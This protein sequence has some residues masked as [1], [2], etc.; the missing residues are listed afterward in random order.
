[1]SDTQVA[2]VF[3]ARLLLEADTR[4]TPAQLLAAAKGKA[5]DPTVFDDERFTPFFWTAEISSNRLDAYS[6]RMAPSSLKNYAE[7]AKAGISFQDSHMTDGVHRTFGQS[8]GA[9]YFGPGNKQR[10]EGIAAVEADFYS[11]LGLDG[12][13][14]AY[15]NKVRAGI[16][17]DVSIGFYGGTYRCSIC[18]RDMRDYTDWQNYCPHY[19]GQK[20][21]I[22]D[23]KTGKPTGERQTVE[24]AIED[25]HLAETSGVYDGA[26][27]EASILVIKAKELA[28]A[29]KLDPKEAR[30]IEDRY[31]VR[32]PGM[33][34]AF[35]VGLD[36]RA[37]QS[38]TT[39]TPKEGTAMTLEEQLRALAAEIGVPEGGD[40]VAH[41][42]T[43]ATDTG[44]RIAT[45]VT[46]RDEQVR[47]AL[48]HIGLTSEG[49]DVVAVIRAN[50][51]TLTALRENAKY[52]EAWRTKLIGEA[53][54]EATRALGEKFTKERRDAL[55]KLSPEEL[56]ERRDTWAEM[57]DALLPGGRKTVNGETETTGQRPAHGAPVPLAAYRAG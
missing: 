45:A 13:I 50:A 5:L 46:A 11:L 55:A 24:A 18:D 12:L 23:G 6:T 10:P 16:T 25:A 57:G 39:P 26:T 8:L 38:G 40:I 1:M 3:P 37:R 9:R 21:A 33:A 28:D 35:A 52:G 51:P 54:D 49:D 22:L 34:P 43:L 2:Q 53:A 41:V 44:S 7:D 32:I 36:L 15:V 56:I 42:R 30:F 29:G 48:A 47:G 31:R 4:A 14:D 17:K 19:P 20:V 27:P